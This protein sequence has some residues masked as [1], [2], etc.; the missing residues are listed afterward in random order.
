MWIGDSVLENMKFMRSNNSSFISLKIFIFIVFGAI[1]FILL[2]FIRQPIV[3]YF[4]FRQ[5]QTA[6][7]SYWMMREGWRLNYQT[8]IG[9]YPWSIPFEF[10]IYQL[11]VTIIAQ[12]GKLPLDPVGR[13]VSFLFL[14]ACAWPAFNLNKRLALPDETPWV[15]LILL[16]STPI[17][18]FWGRT[19]MIETAAVFFTFAAIPFFIDF[20]KSKNTTKSALHFAFWMTLG[21]LQKSTTALPV[22]LFLIVIYLFSFVKEKK[23][24]LLFSRKVFVEL[25]AIFFSV[26]VGFLWSYYSDLVRQQNTLGEQLTTKSLT[27]WFYGTLDQRMDFN[28]IRT[29]LWD[30]VFQRDVASI[31]GITILVVSLFIAKDKIRNVILSGVILFILPIGIFINLHFVHDYYQTSAVLFLIGSLAVGIVSIGEKFNRKHPVV[32]LIIFVFF[33]S[34][35][36]GFFRY[37]WQYLSMP[38]DNMQTPSLILAD[39]IDRYTDNDSAIIVFGND[40]NSDITY[41]SG[42]KSFAVPDWLVKYEEVWANPSRFVG[43]KELGSVVYC[44]QGDVHK[45]FYLLDTYDGTME[46]HLF[47][48][49]NCYVWLPNVDEVRLRTEEIVLPMNFI[50]PKTDLPLSSSNVDY[51]ADCSGSIDKVNGVKLPVDI[52]ELDDGYLLVEGWVAQDTINGILPERVYLALKDEKSR[53]ILFEA[54]NTRR[55]DVGDYFNLPMLIDSGYKVISDISDVN[56]GNYILDLLI[57]V[58]GKFEYCNNLAVP[59]TIR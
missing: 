30:R 34:N 36:H 10:P 32:L 15:F 23:I 29:V 57:D 12:W 44:V 24:T 13:F 14:I 58:G 40:W 7:T 45:L 54:Q 46:K 38:L 20:L 9:G 16:W 48:I 37:Y 59:V 26:G 3:E 42:R 19:F 49:A 52:V 6:L 11:I 17:Y 51:S 25:G 1:L 53:T 4:G 27:A 22:I 8:P 35:L 56:A 41:Y 28:V 18:V 2:F 50:S 43:G 21:I 33:T 55:V 39:V 5:T 31:L 47:E